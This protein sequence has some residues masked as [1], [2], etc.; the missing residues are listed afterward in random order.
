[1]SLQS[2]QYQ[3]REYSSFPLRVNSRVLVLMAPLCWL[4]YTVCYTSYS[5]SSLQDQQRT[6]CFS[7]W[8]RTWWLLAPVKSVGMPG[9]PPRLQ[10]WVKQWSHSISWVFAG[11]LLK[12]TGLDKSAG[13]QRATASIKSFWKVTFFV[14]PTE[15]AENGL[16][17][18]CGGE[19]GK[20]NN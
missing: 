15:W 11:D 12:E 4:F 3:H 20:H 18:S 17:D 14:A 1:M 6:C 10:D 5:C 8:K 19:L 13:Y 7:L 9:Y 2:M 16:G